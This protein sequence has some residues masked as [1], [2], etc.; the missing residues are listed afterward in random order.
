MQRGAIH[1]RRRGAHLVHLV[2]QVL[3]VVAAP[4]LDRTYTSV[5]LLLFVITRELTLV[6]SSED[7]RRFASILFVLLSFLQTDQQIQRIA[8]PKTAIEKSV[9]AN[10]RPHGIQKD[11]LR[12]PKTSRMEEKSNC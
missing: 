7:R 4:L 12:P 11:D 8:S 5:A 10:A 3:T 9:Y 6:V 1:G 2:V